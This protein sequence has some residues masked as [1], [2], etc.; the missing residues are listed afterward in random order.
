MPNADWSKTKELQH[1]QR[2]AEE[3]ARI[4]VQENSI[5][6]HAFIMTCPLPN[7]AIRFRFEKEKWETLKSELCQYVSPDYEKAKKIL[8][9]EHCEIR[10]EIEKC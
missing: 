2:F 1:L 9:L 10:Y 8:T 5:Q 6:I 3:F 4:N 7:M